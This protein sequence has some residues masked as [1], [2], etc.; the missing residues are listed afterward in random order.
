MRYS[1]L[2]GAIVAVGLM[3]QM[4][5]ASH[6]VTA[7]QT[8]KIS[9][10]ELTGAMGI[11]SYRT[12]LNGQQ[13]DGDFQVTNGVPDSNG[14]T[15]TYSGSFKDY[16]KGFAATQNCKGTIKLQRPIAN[17]G[18]APLKVTWT[19]TGGV[20]CP[21]PV[22][23]PANPPITVNLVETMP[24]A[25]SSGNFQASNSNTLITDTA[26][27][28]TW[29]KW[30]VSDTTPLNCR[31]NAA[32]NP[33]APGPTIVQKLLPGSIVDVQYMGLDSFITSG[34]ESWLRV[35]MSSKNTKCFIRANKQFVK[36]Q[37]MQF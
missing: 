36:P 32:T 24:V 23:S 9:F 33:T 8:T 29:P 22:S 28:A 18:S 17:P 7:N 37:P 14:T 6:Y 10:Q 2:F 20:G 3:P 26:G 25:D 31:G 16:R 19:I 15:K 21:S 13:W 1:L 35:Q 12:T 34:G 27:L 4:A 30:I 5:Q 11:G